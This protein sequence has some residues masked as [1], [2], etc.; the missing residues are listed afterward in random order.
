M[1]LSKYKLLGEFQ[2]WLSHK[3]FSY[4]GSYDANDANVHVPS[5]SE[6]APPVLFRGPAPQPATR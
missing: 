1:H 2:L 5:P 3:N 4:D 6:L